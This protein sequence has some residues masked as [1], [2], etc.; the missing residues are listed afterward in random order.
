[1]AFRG[2]RESVSAAAG[3]SVG[4]P[5]KRGVAAGVAR[6]TTVKSVSFSK[7]IGAGRGGSRR[8]VSTKGDDDDDDDF[9]DVGKA[10]AAFESKTDAMNEV[11]MCS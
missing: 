7:A 2:P 6:P 8:S 10:H 9:F 4:S 3:D 5:L 11:C 1:M